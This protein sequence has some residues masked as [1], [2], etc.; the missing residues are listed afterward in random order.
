M[1]TALLF[2]DGVVQYIERRVVIE[3]L[4]DPGSIPELVMRRRVLGK[5]T[6]LLFPI[7]AKRSTAMVA[8]LDVGL[9]IR[10]PKTL[11]ICVVSH[12]RRVLGSCEKIENI[13]QTF[14]NIFVITTSVKRNFVNLHGSFL[15]SVN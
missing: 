4:L 15:Q 11:C 8:E 9:A 1:S 2:S 6:S 14:Y 5:D 3:K 12:T 13:N 7:G 10:I